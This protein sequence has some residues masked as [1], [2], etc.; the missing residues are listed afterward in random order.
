V[1]PILFI[2]IFSA[3]V[4]WACQQLLDFAKPE[5]INIQHQKRLEKSCI[6]DELMRWKW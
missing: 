3:L 2:I 5:E 4:A 1:K 6:G